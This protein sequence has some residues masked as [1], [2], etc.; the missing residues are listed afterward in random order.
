MTIANHYSGLAAGLTTG[1]ATE[2]IRRQATGSSG[3]DQS[4]VM[5]SEANVTRLVNKL[6][7]MRGA[8]LKL[9][10]FMS[11]QDAHVLPEQIEQILRRVQN[12]A[13][14]MPQ[15]Q[16]E[17]CLFFVFCFESLSLTGN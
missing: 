14:Y 9:G 12:A 8:A 3:T 1:A 4:S 2:Y 6:S 16:M 5:M 17:V 10:Q 11:I 13:H 15:W 7:Q